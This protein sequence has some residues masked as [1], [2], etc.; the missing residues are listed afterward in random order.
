MRM[1]TA[2]LNGRRHDILLCDLPARGAG[3]QARAVLRVWYGA[4]S[5]LAEG[6]QIEKNDARVLEERK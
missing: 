5:V 4:L 6:V 1:I 3:S 2:T